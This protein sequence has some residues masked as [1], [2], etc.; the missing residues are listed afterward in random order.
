L[1]A[2]HLARLKQQSAQLADLFDQ[3]DRFAYELAHLFDLY[4]DR[5][6]RPGQSGEPPSLLKIYNLP[7]PV[8]RQVTSD[9]QIIAITHPSE[10]LVLARRL[11]LEPSLEFRLLAASL[12]GFT[13][14]ESPEMV[15]SI[16]E[17]W[18]GSGMDDRLLA[19]VMNNGLTSF[20]EDAPERLIEQI[21]IWL[22]SSDLYVQQVGLRALIPILSAAQYENLPVFYHM[23]SPFV[24]KAPLRIRPDV[25]EALRNLAA[26]SPKE[27]VYF[28]N[29][30]LN[31][32]D[33]PDA[34]LMA[35]QTLPYFPQESQDSLRTAWRGM[36]R[37]D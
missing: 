4:S 5:T 26:H 12:L 30:N 1:P 37:H 17:E 20:R 29:Q 19:I 16:I 23:L 33:N 15:L 2:I 13:R 28:L 27:T 21:Q 36:A 9:L 7:K 8:L 10:T 24:R 22:Q 31:A 25:L 32:P 11:W 35:R 34:A 14:V 6:H 3:P 18:A